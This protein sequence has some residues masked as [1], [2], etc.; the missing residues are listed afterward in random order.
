MKHFVLFSMILIVASVIVLLMPSCDVTEGLSTR[1]GPTGGGPSAH[2]VP[3]PATF[4]R[5]SSS[6]AAAADGASDQ[7]HLLHGTLDKQE[8]LSK[9]IESV[10]LGKVSATTTQKNGIASTTAPV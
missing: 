4:L 7:D 3:I 1:D 8:R 5:Q 9:T 2:E 10:P 6:T